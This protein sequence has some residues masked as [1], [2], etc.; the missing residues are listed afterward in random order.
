MSCKIVPSALPHSENKSLEIK[1]FFSLKKVIIGKTRNKKE[2]KN[3][4][5]KTYLQRLGF[6]SRCPCI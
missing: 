3:N 5:P 2:I 4:F 6:F 1:F